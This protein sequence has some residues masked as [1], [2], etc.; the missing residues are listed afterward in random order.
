MC[1]QAQTPKLGNYGHRADA[2]WGLAAEEWSRPDCGGTTLTPALAAQL[3][4]CIW[5]KQG[6]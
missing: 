6:R 1:T 5:K 2:K 4:H 3:H